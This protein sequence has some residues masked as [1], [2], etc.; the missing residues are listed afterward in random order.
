M[1]V[2]VRGRWWWCEFQIAGERFRRSTGVSKGKPRRMAEKVERAIRTK[3]ENDLRRRRG[4]DFALSEACAL[5]LAERGVLL[6]EDRKQQEAQ[7][8]RICTLFDGDPIVSEIDGA[9]VARALGRRRAQTVG[10]KAPRPPS[11]SAVVRDTI[12]PLRRVLNYVASVHGAELQRISWGKLTTGQPRGRG[13]TLRADQEDAFWA[14]IRSD[15]REFIEF[16]ILAT[17]RRS[18]LLAKWED[19]D[20][21]RSTLTVKRLK[22]RPGAAAEY[23]EVRLGARAAALIEAQR[24]RHPVMIWTYEVQGWATD[25]SSGKKIRVPTGERR[26]I[27]AEGLKQIWRRKAR[28]AAA[29]GFRVHDLRHHGASALVRATGSLEL[30]RDRL[31]HSSITVTSQFYAHVLDNDARLA[32][33]A[34]EGAVAKPPMEPDRKS[35]HKS[36][37]KPAARNKRKA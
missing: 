4:R 2:F 16:A 5:W 31:D 7:L 15:Y 35:P 11:E 10:R 9:L 29:P 19:W 21:A 36:P 1:S 12:A 37:H 20:P 33:E 22:K 34:I 28:V 18:Q 8:L 13:R 24:G 6:R 23:R 32:A 17:Q 30:A 14:A 3:L 26:P 25:P 27:T